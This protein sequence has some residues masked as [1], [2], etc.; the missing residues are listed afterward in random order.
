MRTLLTQL[1]F[2]D[3]LRSLR[4]RNQNT[5]RFAEMLT[6]IRMEISSDVWESYEERI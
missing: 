4:D 6:E 1:A 5:G 2:S 3:R